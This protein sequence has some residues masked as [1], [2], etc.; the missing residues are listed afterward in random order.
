[1]KNPTYYEG[2]L[3][4][5][6]ASGIG[7]AVLY[8]RGTMILITHERLIRSTSLNKYAVLLCMSVHLGKCDVIC[9][10]ECSHGTL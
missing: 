9:P 5:C 2:G 1:M 7:T 3:F 10:C 8:V 4:L 6:Y